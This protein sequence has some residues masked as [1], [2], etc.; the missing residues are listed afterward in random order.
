MLKKN[1]SIVYF[2]I[3]LVLGSAIAL[4][5][6]SFMN[7][8]ANHEFAANLTGQQEVPPVQTQATG[9][10][11]FVPVTPDNQTISFFVNATNIQ[12]LTQGHIHS[13][14]QGENGPIVST[15]FAFNP[16]QDPSQ[17]G[18]MLNGNISAVNLEGPMEGK[19]MP[20]L[21]SAMK[22]GSTYVN[23]HTQQNPNGEIRGQLMDIP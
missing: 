22:N 10:A 6:S 7:V 21:I 12:G 8:Y 23:F 4:S 5:S 16:V 13:G 18:I 11:I 20:D 17:N 14:V 9:E 19:T 2:A 3:A 1:I 15:L